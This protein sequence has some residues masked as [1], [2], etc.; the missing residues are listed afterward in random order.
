MIETL[1]QTFQTAV[2]VLVGVTAVLSA[3]S[4]ILWAIVGIMWCYDRWRCYQSG[5]HEY[6]RYVLIPG[7]AYEERCSKCGHRIG[8]PAGIDAGWDIG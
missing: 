7:V 4:L 8:Y 5:G 6:V 2:V 1:A 3:I